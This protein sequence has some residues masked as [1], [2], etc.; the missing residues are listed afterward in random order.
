MS[1]FE[2]IG[3]WLVSVVSDYEAE[4]AVNPGDV[5]DVQSVN[6]SDSS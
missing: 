2:Y 6:L 3:T 4:L 5:A 1:D